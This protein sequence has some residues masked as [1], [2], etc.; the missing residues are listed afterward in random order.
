MKGIKNVYD[1][2]INKRV[3][4]DNGLSKFLYGFQQGG[5]KTQLRR[6]QTCFSDG[7]GLVR[8]YAS[9]IVKFFQI[10]KSTDDD[11]F[12]M[13]DIFLSFLKKCN[14]ADTIQAVMLLDGAVAYVDQNKDMS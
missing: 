7:Y 6:S 13:N 5:F 11:F 9:I 14:L 1:N 8:G 2:T 10:G 12:N 4:L 3:P